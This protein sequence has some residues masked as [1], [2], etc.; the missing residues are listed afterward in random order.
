MTWGSGCGGL[1][2]GGGGGG[3]GEY[4]HWGVSKSEM[5][6]SRGVWTSNA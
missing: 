2:G 3:L 6:S 1:F 5:L 4:K